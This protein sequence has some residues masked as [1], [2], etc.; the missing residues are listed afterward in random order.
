MNREGTVIYITL[1]LLSVISDYELEPLNNFHAP[2]HLQT[3][4]V[5]DLVAD[6]ALHQHEVELVV[7]FSQ[8]VFLPG[9]FAHQAHCGVGQNRL[10]W[11]GKD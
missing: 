8:G 4:W 10:Q 9:F 3:V 2:L 6:G 1:L 7:L 11:I 5:D